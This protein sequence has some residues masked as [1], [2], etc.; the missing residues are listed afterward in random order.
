MVTLLHRIVI[1]TLTALSCSKTYSTVLIV[2]IPVNTFTNQ[3]IS[4]TFAHVASYMWLVRI[5]LSLEYLAETFFVATDQ[6]LLAILARDC[7]THLYVSITHA[8][9]QLQ[10]SC[11]SCRSTY[12][13]M[14]A[15]TKLQDF[16]DYIAILFAAAVGHSRILTFFQWGAE[17]PCSPLKT[18]QYHSTQ[19]HS[20]CLCI[21]TT[22]TLL[23]THLQK[24]AWCNILYIL[25]VMYSL[26]L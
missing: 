14:H 21:W 1:S 26:D 16:I 25:T 3:V 20:K 2:L 12:K 23:N 15:T 10:L 22:M 6:K 13:S 5:I 17:V 24:Y 18:P 4:Q 19:P 11:P 9:M 8:V 7:Y